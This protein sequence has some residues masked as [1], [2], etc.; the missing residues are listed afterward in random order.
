[1][2]LTGGEVSMQTNV[3]WFQY[4]DHALETRKIVLFS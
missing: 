1:L 3:Q 2:L 4:D